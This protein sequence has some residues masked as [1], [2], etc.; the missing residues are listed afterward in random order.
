MRPVLLTLL[1]ALIA[2]LGAERASGQVAD[3]VS[4]VTDTVE[5]AAPTPVAEVVEQ[6]EAAVPAPVTDV[7]GKSAPAVPA[8][9]AETVD[10]VGAAAP[11]PK[12]AFSTTR[13]SAIRG[14]SSGAKAV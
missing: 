14:F 3:P 9:V 11:A 5:Q 13:A 8:P 2:L 7:V 6:A 12:P 10:E 1:V 4:G